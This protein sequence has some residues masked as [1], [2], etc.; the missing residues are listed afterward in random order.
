MISHS[1]FLSFRFLSKEITA[2]LIF[3]VGY[4]KHLLQGHSKSVRAEDCNGNMAS[5]V[6]GIFLIDFPEDCLKKN[7]GKRITFLHFLCDG[8]I[9]LHARELNVISAWTLSLDP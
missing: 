8:R 9:I 3:L 7:R 4:C 1:P 2:H 5:Q 6:L